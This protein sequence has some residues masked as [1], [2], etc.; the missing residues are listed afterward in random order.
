MV[1]HLIQ[2][3]VGAKTFFA[4]VILSEAK[5]LSFLMQKRCLAALNMTEWHLLIIADLR[6]M[7]T[8]LTI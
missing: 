7:Y 3:Y 8:A 6:Q 1:P 5:N 2:V 4:H